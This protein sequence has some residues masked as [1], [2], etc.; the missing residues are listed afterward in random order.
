[1]ERQSFM[2]AVNK[3][4]EKL[5]PPGGG[6]GYSHHLIWSKAFESSGTRG[7]LAPTG[8]KASSYQTWIQGSSKQ[9]CVWTAAGSSISVKRAALHTLLSSLSSW[10]HGQASDLQQNL[11]ISASDLQ[12]QIHLSPRQEAGQRGAVFQSWVPGPSLIQQSPW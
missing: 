4:G 1:M 8:C 10:A 6:D 9:R 2:Q 5:W 11:Y 12:T 3:S 7:S